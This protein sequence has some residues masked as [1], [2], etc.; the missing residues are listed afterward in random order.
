ML[1][2]IAAFAFALLLMEATAAE[3][4]RVALVIGKWVKR[5]PPLLLGVLVF[6]LTHS[7]ATTSVAGPTPEEYVAHVGGDA[8]IV[9]AGE[10]TIDGYKLVC[11][12]RPTVLD[13]KL[14]DYAAAY[15]GFIILNPTLLAKV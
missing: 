3:A 13:P 8:K 11:G 4:R 9:A 15:P 10:L 7:F 6:A 1:N 5:R 2:R 12:Q 14:D